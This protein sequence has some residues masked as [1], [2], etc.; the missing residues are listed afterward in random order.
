MAEIKGLEFDHVIVEAPTQILRQ[1]PQG[2]CD[3]Y[4]ALTRATQSLH[5]LGPMP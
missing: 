3:L 2:W 4:V 1:S 5:I